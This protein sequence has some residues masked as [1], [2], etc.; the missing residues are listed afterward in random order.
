MYWRARGLRRGFRELGATAG[1]FPICELAGI[2]L[3]E[4]LSILAAAHAECGDFENAIATQQQ[5]IA[6]LRK[7]GESQVPCAAALKLYESRQAFRDD[8]W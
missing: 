7:G 8:S 2:V 4:V 5:A 6:L 3:E 1:W